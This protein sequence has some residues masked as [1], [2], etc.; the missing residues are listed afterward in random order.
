[1]VF[2]Y[3]Q[4]FFKIDWDCTAGDVGDVGSEI[5]CRPGG[6]RYIVILVGIHVLCGRQ[7]ILPSYHRY[8]RDNN[9][10]YVIRIIHCSSSLSSLWSLFHC[11]ISYF[12]KLRDDI[13]LVWLCQ[14][15]QRFFMIT[16]SFIYHNMQKED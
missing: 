1:M 10:S 12:D 3:N 9:P 5:I 7:R 15:W 4:P 6:A 13:I 8:S 16:R 2:Y 14:N 11:F